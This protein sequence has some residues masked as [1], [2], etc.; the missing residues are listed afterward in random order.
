MLNS[1]IIN[2]WLLILLHVTCAHAGEENIPKIQFRDGHL[3][4]FSDRMSDLIRFE[5][6]GNKIRLKRDWDER[7]EKAM[8][9]TSPKQIAF[10]DLIKQGVPEQI[11]K[12]HA[13]IIAQRGQLGFRGENSN[14]GLPWFFSRLQANRSGGAGSSGGGRSRRISFSNTD[15]LGYANTKD[16]LIRFTF[17]ELQSEQRTLRLSDDGGGVV[18]FCL[19]HDE[20]LIRFR[21][22][23]GGNVQVVV[24]D[25]DKAKAVAA[26]NFKSL[27]AESPK[28]V[29]DLL[30]P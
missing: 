5:W 3:E 24:V 19:F 13:E 25:G 2:G 27:I 14:A 15:L 10:A 28:V 7:H 22:S 11:A 18:E 26:D 9:G 23:K 17:E 8:A 29:D 30:F 12:R 4:T 20:V 16:D 1:K 6:D 21:Q